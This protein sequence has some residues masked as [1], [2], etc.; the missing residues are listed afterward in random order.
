MG[1]VQLN[2]FV[3]WCK[4]ATECMRALMSKDG[5][6]VENRFCGFLGLETLVTW[7][8]RGIERVRRHMCGN[9]ENVGHAHG[10]LVDDEGDIEEKIQVNNAV[11]DNE[12]GGREVTVLPSWKKMWGGLKKR[13]LTPS[14]WLKTDRIML[15]T[16]HWCAAYLCRMGERWGIQA[17]SS[18]ADAEMLEKFFS[19]E[20]FPMLSILQCVEWDID[21]EKDGHE[22][23]S[24]RRHDVNRLAELTGEMSTAYGTGFGS[25]DARGTYNVELYSFEF[26]SLVNSY[27]ASDKKHRGGNRE[28]VKVG[29]A[30]SRCSRNIWG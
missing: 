24:I 10:N 11:V 17:Y 1:I 5:E 3:A 7:Y 2:A 13:S 4:D 9:A 29:L 26:D 8:K 16:V 6:N 28:S 18:R 22:F 12:L 25:Y 30:H 21:D 23:M 14:R 27:P 15:N 20:M 19:S